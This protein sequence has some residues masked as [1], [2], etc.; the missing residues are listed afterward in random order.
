MFNLSPS[1]KVISLALTP[2]K[3]YS[4]TSQSS[5]NNDSTPTPNTVG[6]F[7]FS[8]QPIDGKL[9]CRDVPSTVPLITRAISAKH[10][11]LD[12][13]A[14]TT[15]SDTDAEVAAIDAD[16]TITSVPMQGLSSPIRRSTRFTISPVPPISYSDTMTRSPLL[17]RSPSSHTDEREDL[18]HTGPLSDVL[19]TPPRRH[20]SHTA[21]SVKRRGLFDIARKTP[22]PRKRKRRR[23]STSGD[24]DTQHMKQR[25]SICFV[26]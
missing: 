5:T 24:E 25:L 23:S 14:T 17:Y 8:S 26:L 10:R 18:Q 13:F 4:F 15:E 16:C 22:S 1:K 2:T 11:I 21:I 19:N 12:S 3:Q 9:T 20:T 7:I 6:Q